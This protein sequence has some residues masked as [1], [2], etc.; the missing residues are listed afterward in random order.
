MFYRGLN[1]IFTG[2][3]MNTDVIE[4]ILQPAAA[5]AALERALY[6]LAAQKQIADRWVWTEKDVATWETELAA[7][8]TTETGLRDRHGAAHA[9]WSVAEADWSVGLEELHAATVTGVG[10]ARIRWR[11]DAE[12][13]LVLAAL[14]AGGSTA[15]EILREAAGWE[16]AWAELEPTLV[17]AP[18]LTLAAFQAQHAA[19]RA[20]GQALRVAEVRRRLAAGQVRRGPGRHRR[21]GASLVRRGHRGLPRQERHPRV[22]G[23]RAHHVRAPLPRSRQTPPRRQTPARQYH[24][25]PARRGVGQLPKE[26]SGSSLFVCFFIFICFLKVG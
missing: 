8:T 2:A 24:A 21:C 11:R 17:P 20:A 23:F 14:E 1:A 18:G 15:E 5:D 7:I 6:T 13:R 16:A 10:V 19:V 26:A 25:H 3:A 22:A 4:R 9:A 12:R